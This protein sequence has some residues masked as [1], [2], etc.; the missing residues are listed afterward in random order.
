MTL[1]PVSPAAHSLAC[2]EP[3]FG[4]ICRR[5]C[6]GAA[7]DGGKVR[8]TSDQQA[9]IAVFLLDDHEVV[10]RGVADI[11]EG[12]PGIIVVGEGKNASEALA[13]VRP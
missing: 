9:P 2:T 11:L 7:R 12:D 8:L 10:R 1:R 3:P 6:G 5:L 13:R 4:G